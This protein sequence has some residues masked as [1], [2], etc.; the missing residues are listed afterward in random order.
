MECDHE[1]LKKVRCPKSFSNLKSRSS[2]VEKNLF[3]GG[4]KTS[5]D[6]PSVGHHEVI[7]KIPGKE[8]KSFPSRPTRPAPLA[9][10]SLSETKVVV[11][12]RDCF[13]RVTTTLVSD[14]KLAHL[15]NYA[16][17]ST[18]PC[19]ADDEFY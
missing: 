11:H 8:Y 17:G 10:S 4:T 6:A 16:A 13:S 14:V 1:V 2:F 15:G 3:Q 18:A 5:R 19:S 7:E 9:H 12:S